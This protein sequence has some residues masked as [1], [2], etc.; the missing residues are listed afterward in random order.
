LRK[1]FNFI[2]DKFIF[3]WLQISKLIGEL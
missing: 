1:R 2:S 3:I